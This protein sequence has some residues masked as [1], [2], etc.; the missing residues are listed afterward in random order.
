MS[1]AMTESTRPLV[2]G[3]G[4]E[5]A[6]R[7]PAAD[8]S[9]AVVRCLLCGSSDLGNEPY[10][11]EYGG[12]RY[13]GGRCRACGFVFLTRQPSAAV[14]ARMYGPTYFE[15][16]YHCGHSA[17]PYFEREAEEMAAARTLLA[18]LE[19]ES[20]V[21]RLLEVGCAGGFFLAAARE[22]GWRPT[23]VEY[24]EE[25]SRF[26]RDKLGLDVRTGSLE[27]AGFADGSFDAVYM[28]D[29]LEHVPDPLATLSEVRRALRPGGLLLLAGPIAI[30]SLVHQFGLW[31]YARLRRER[32]LRLPPYHL[33]EFAP[34][35]LR[36]GFHRAGFDV[37]FLRQS[38]IPP[39]LAPLPGQP[40]ALHAARL[41]FEIPNWLWTTIT[42][43][44]GDRVVALARRAP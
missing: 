44:D 41:A 18:L 40:F 7:G 22:R 37:L 39:R 11:Y 30:H 21:G 19:R 26:A 15:S 42:G 28:G 4:A 5:G 17:A 25:A 3:G 34:A 6:T 24:S 43:R 32:L 31:A 9:G 29:V 16:D 2:P 36:L 8:A 12:E 10:A 23:G 38:K 14:L 13:P 27:D 1:G 33:L 35:T 20:P